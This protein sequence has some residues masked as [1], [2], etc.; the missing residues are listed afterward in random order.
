MEALWSSP[1]ALS[2]YDIQD[3]LAR[4]SAKPLAATTVLTVLSRLEKKGFVQR[5][6]SERPHRYAAI[7]SREDHMAELMHEVLGGADDRAAVLARFVGQVSPAEAEA[8]RRLLNDGN[9]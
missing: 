4:A 8:L 7:A 3:T 5:E 6:R 9:A 2:A 1:D